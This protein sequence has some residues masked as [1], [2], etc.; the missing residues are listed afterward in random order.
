MKNK[1]SLKKNI[2]REIINTKSRFIS[3]MAIIGISVG[4][5]TG[6]RSASPSMVETARQYLNDQHLADISIIS[7]VGFDDDDIEEI[8][9]VDC[10]EQVMPS[11]SADLIITQ[12]NVDSVVRVYGLPQTTNTNTDVINEPVLIEGH[13]PVKD[14]ECVIESYYLRMANLKIGDTIRFNESVEGKET[15]DFIKHLEYKIVGVVDTPMYLTYSRGNTTV[16]NGSV[17]F[18]MMIKPDEFCIERYT[19]VYVRTRASSAGVSDYSDEYAD[20]VEQDVKDIEAVSGSCVERFNVTTLADAKKELADAQKE[21]ADKKQEA[22]EQIADGEKQLADGEK[23]FADKITEAEQKLADGQKE[24]DNAKQQLSDGQSEASEKLEEA[25][26]KLTDAQ[27]QYSNAQNQY[28]NAKLEYDTKISEAQS[29]LDAA[30]KEYNNQYTIFYSSTKPNAETKLTLMKAA[31]DGCNDLIN[32][33]KTEIEKLKS[34]ELLTD[35]IRAKIEEQNAK[36]DEYQNKLDEYQ[37]QYDE[38][39]RQLAEGEA[40]LADAKQQLDAAQ[41]EFEE[42]KAFGAAQLNDAQ[43]QLNDAQSQLENGKLEYESAMTTG[44]IEMQSGQ[45]KITEAEKE[46][47]N[48]RK[49]LEEQ[50]KIGLETLKLAREKLESGRYEA[51]T[52][53]EEAEEKLNDAQDA[54]S[55]LENAKWYVYDRDENPGYSGLTEDADRVDNIAVVFPAFFLIVAA[56]VCLTTMTRMVEERRTEIGTLKAL[57]YS[58]FDICKK[59]FIYG[60]AAAVVGS[61]I[62]GFI[63]AFTLPDVIVS[64]YGMMYILPDTALVISWDSFVMSA[65]IG[66]VCTCTVAVAACFR[67]LKINP[68]TLMRPKAPKPGKRIL[69]EY[70]KPVWAH[71]NFTSKVTA[72]NLFRYKARFL[73]TVI[74]VAGCT[75]LIVAGFGLKDSLTVIADRQYGELTKYDQIY[76]LSETETAEKKSY[77]ISQFRK[78]ERL[79]NVLLGYQGWT[80]VYGKE[81]ADKMNLHI[82]IGQ[83]IEEFE[84]MFVLRDRKTHEKV[85]LDNDGAVINERMSEVLNIKVGDTIHLTIDSDPYTCQVSGI[86]ENYAGNY[87]YMTPEYYRTVT[88]KVCKYNVVFT[89]TDPQYK[90]VEREIANDW[91]KNDDIVTV[92]LISEQV[93]SIKDTLNSLDFIVFVMIF[94]AGLLAVVVLYNLTNINIAERMREIATIKVLGFYNLETANYVYRE[95]IILTG[96][97]GV[98]GLFL[99]SMLLGFIIQSIQM[100]MVMFPKEIA[101]LSYVYGFLLTFAFSM[102]VNFIMYF[103]MNK[104][105]MVE[106]LKSIE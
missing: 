8:K 37:K 35:D 9:N 76:A 30:Q 5:Y 67:E 103:K 82:I 104:I 23:E 33:T 29:K 53:L 62:G 56:L 54:I 14:N 59:Y 55:S 60:S 36:L 72:R 45:S 97:G 96:V 100:D 91:M 73:M 21:Y 10:V 47:E 1:K 80:D 4:F 13:L 51:K 90:D 81:K 34:A 92:A 86:I 40:A 12:E 66:I 93:E 106:S 22:E 68:A 16:G 70:I 3:I 46:L 19:N 7:T 15:A 78:D 94:C 18:Y 79:K 31:I 84:N 25:K 28:N 63:G 85:P 6:L 32:K 69:L 11:Y 99:G 39:S 52:G 61:I 101:P 17:L 2:I 48:G 27:T 38:G 77:L 71:M 64:T 43:N 87:L 95:N 88:G 24:L 75:A 57:G 98:A 105:S 50:K 49:E 58:N 44:M 65:L 102:L 89:G 83:D 42:Q 41:T 74:G 26:Q 20:M